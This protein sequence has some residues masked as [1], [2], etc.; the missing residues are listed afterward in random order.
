MKKIL[1]LLAIALG[2]V[3]INHSCKPDPEEELGSIYGSY[4]D[5][6]RSVRLVAE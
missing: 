1:T 5:T 4:R 6:G 2:L 3:L